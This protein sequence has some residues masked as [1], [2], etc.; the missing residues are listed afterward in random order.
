METSVHAGLLT[1]IKTNVAGLSPGC[2]TR[3][4]EDAFYNNAAVIMRPVAK[5][6]P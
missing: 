5:K 1:W 2:K 6:N 4:S 3:G